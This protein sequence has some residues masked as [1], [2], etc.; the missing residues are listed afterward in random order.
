[1][2]TIHPQTL[3][4]FEDYAKDDILPEIEFGGT[5]CKRVD[6]VFDENN[7]S[8]LKGEAMVIRGRSVWRRMTYNH[9]YIYKLEYV[10]PR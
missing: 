6:I 5:K 3:K 10:P 2:N 1:M 8:N 7:K 9:Q 4:P